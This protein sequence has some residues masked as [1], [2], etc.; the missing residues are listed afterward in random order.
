MAKDSAPTP[1]DKPDLE[2]IIRRVAEEAGPRAVFGDAVVSGER[3]VVPVARV[4]YGAGGGWGGPSADAEGQSDQEGAG[5]GFGVGATPVGFIEVTPEFARF[6][7]IVNWVPL[8]IGAMIVS[9]I[10]AVFLGFGAHRRR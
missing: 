2:R 4:A 7:P 8:A 1:A 6:H 3:I 5:G 10:W 9:A